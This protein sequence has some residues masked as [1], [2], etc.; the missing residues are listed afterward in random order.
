MSMHEAEVKSGQRFEFGRNWARFSTRLTP[1]RIRYSEKA[2]L[3]MLQVEDLSG[4]SFLDAGSG[5]GL[6]SLAARNLGASIHSFDYDG[7]S[8]ACTRALRDEYCPGEKSWK[9]EEGSVL[10]SAYLKSLGQFDVVYSWGVLHHTG[11]MWSAI[12]NV[13]MN[14]ASGG[15]LYIAIYND[16]GFKSRVWQR[17]KRT[18]CSGAP[19]KALVS[20]LFVPYFFLRT[21][22]R[23]VLL[24]RNLFREY[25]QRRGM[26]VTH[27]W[28]DWLG[29]LP[30]EVATVTRI[31]RFLKERGFELQNI[32]TTNGRGN[33]EFVFL[34]VAD[35]PS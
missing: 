10:D 9:V 32:W 2:I 4:K 16:E 7:A 5:S 20:C 21:I 23:S 34:K 1:E 15:L 24:R 18:Y 27:D 6:S 12:E 11:D 35:D 28:H 19:G 25:K 3:D 17:I 29:G 22:G 13:S 8:V 33:N 31:F 30:F 26:S 14:V